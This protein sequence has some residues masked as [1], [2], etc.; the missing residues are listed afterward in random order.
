MPRSASRR[1]LALFEKRLVAE[2][3]HA[4][5][6]RPVVG[7]QADADDETGEA[8]ERFGELSELQRVVAAAEAGLE[9][10]LLAVVRP[11]FDVGRRGEERGAPHLRFHFP[12]VLIVQ[13]VAGEHLVDRDRPQRRDVEIPQMLRSASLSASWDRHRSGSRRHAARGSRTGRASTCWQTTSGRS[14][15]SAP[16]RPSHRRAARRSSCARRNVCSSPSCSR[17]VARSCPG[18]GCDSCFALRQDSIG[19]PPFKRPA[20]VRNSSCVACSSRVGDREQL[21]HRQRDALV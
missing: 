2:K 12:Q 16:L 5:L 13:V 1:A 19:S 15:A 17:A 9:H 21:F 11:A 6:D 3:A 18:S 20:S 10:H 4:L 8:H 7:V 14:R